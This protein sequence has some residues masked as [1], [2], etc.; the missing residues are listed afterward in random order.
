MGLLF[1]VGQGMAD[2]YLGNPTAEESLFVDGWLRTNDV[3]RVDRDRYLHIVDRGDNM[4]V[5][6]GENV[7]PRE[8]ERFFE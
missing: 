1:V 2:G 4:I 3:A 6:G 5:S 7:Y 8:I